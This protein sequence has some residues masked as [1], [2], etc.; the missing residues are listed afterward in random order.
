MFIL[1]YYTV[2]KLS[3]TVIVAISNAYPDKKVSNNTMHRLVSNF[4]IQVFATGNSVDR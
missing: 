4:G 2:L 3:G 1:K